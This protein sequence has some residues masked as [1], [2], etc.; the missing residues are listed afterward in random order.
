[1]LYNSLFFLS[2]SSSI[3]LIDNILHVI[4]LT[5]RSP[6][7][8]L[9]RISKRTYT[10]ISLYKE[11]D[12]INDIFDDTIDVLSYFHLCHY[13]ICIIM[14]LTLIFYIIY[15]QFTIGPSH[16]SYNHKKIY[17]QVIKR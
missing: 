13:N 16:K 11:N 8:A 4:P 6:K 15:H 2:P 1:M 5:L 12:I 7:T 10:S 9:Y 3:I 17:K 14:Y